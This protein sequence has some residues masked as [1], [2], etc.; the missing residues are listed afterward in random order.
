MIRYVHDF[1]QWR[2]AARRLINNEIRPTDVTFREDGDQATL[3]DDH[4]PLDP[5]CS[6]FVDQTDT[7]PKGHH[8]PRR[9]TVPRTFMA[10]AKDVAFHRE[11]TRWNILYRTLWRILNEQ[12]HLLELSTDNDVYTLRRMA[13]QVR[14]DAHKA[15]AFVR[16][17]KVTRDRRDYF[18][19]WHCPDHRVLHKI[20][21]FFSRRFKAMN[22]SI[23]TPFESVSWDQQ[24]L[25][26]GPGVPRSEAPKSDELEDLWK[27]YYASIFNPA[28]VKVK[29]MKNEMPVRYWHTMPETALIP[30]LLT[31]ASNRVEK[32]VSH[33]EGYETTAADYIA[34]HEHKSQRSI[35]TL[36]ELTEVAN[37]CTACDLHCH[38]TQTVFGDGPENARLVLVG[39]QPGDAEDR[40]GRPFVGPAGKILDKALAAAG[41]R[42]QDIYL[43]NVVKH[44]KYLHQA[45]MQPRDM[46]GKRRLHQRPNAYEIR[47]C[48]PWLMAEWKNLKHASVLVCLGSTAATSLITRDFKVSR[49]RGRRV[50]SELCENTIATWHPSAILRTRNTD[51][52]QR[53]TSEIVTDLRL[54]LSLL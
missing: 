8:A 26:F 45:E 30:D 46:R 2:D 12:P 20:A 53:K 40:I 32:M 3:F 22:W 43:T 4:H 16:F 6:H 18:I 7:I 1:A 42:R 49:D 24:A 41:I 27:T 37:G 13:K 33:G 15:K 39:E 51:L 44:F 14:R 48:K 50:A 31:A 52:R 28:R 10:L 21:P 47:A 9:F 17:R 5:G 23:L 11:R 36:D 25:H 19:A 54:A 29:A 38:A 34:S 35:G